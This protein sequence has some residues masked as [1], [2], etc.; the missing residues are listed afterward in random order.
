MNF[1]SDVRLLADDREAKVSRGLGNRRASWFRHYDAS[2]ADERLFPPKSELSKTTTRA[3]DLGGS[4]GY[5]LQVRWFMLWPLALGPNPTRAD[6]CPSYTKGQNRWRSGPEPVG[7]G[8]ISSHNVR[9]RKAAPSG[10]EK[11]RGWLAWRSRQC[12]RP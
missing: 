8:L 2:G 5:C 6:S 10:C 7:R 11:G 1:T 12:Q 4:G 3:R 9:I